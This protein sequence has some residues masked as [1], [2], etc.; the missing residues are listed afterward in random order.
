ML[1]FS[2]TACTQQ[3]NDSNEID[4]TK[5]QNVTLYSLTGTMQINAADIEEYLENG[6]YTEPV[7]TMYAADG[8]T[9][10]TLESEV[11]A[12]KNVGLYTEPVVTM[13][14][15]DGRTRVTLKPEVEAYKGVGWYIE[16][17]VTMYAAD[18]RTRVTLESEIEAYKNVGWYTEPV[19]IMYAAD[20]R[21]IVIKE[22]EINI[23][24]SIGWFSE[25]QVS[26]TDSV[27]NE[28]PTNDYFLN[29]A[30]QNAQSAYKKSNP[31]GVDGT[32]NFNT[33]EKV[34]DSFVIVS[35]TMTIFNGMEFYGYCYII[36]ENG[37]W[38]C[39]EAGYIFGAE[40]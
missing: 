6:W 16:P 29:F 25:P 9:R 11:E 23:Y 32:F 35:G 39:S 8:R 33:V 12:Y 17:V 5:Q 7:V 21:T 15:A 3:N 10:V 13:Y 24:K 19:M 40:D 31:E 22:T 14:A 1:V 36:K 30:K 20:G 2:I 34:S 26:N 38:C 28:F 4:E 18:G 37:M 27:N